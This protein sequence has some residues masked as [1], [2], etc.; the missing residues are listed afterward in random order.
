MLATKEICK[1]RRDAVGGKTKAYAY[2]V[3]ERNNKVSARVIVLD[4]K[5]SPCGTFTVKHELLWK[6]KATARRPLERKLARQEEQQRAAAEPE[7]AVEPT[8]PEDT[9]ILTHVQVCN[10]STLLDGLKC[11]QEVTING[12]STILTIAYDGVTNCTT[13]AIVN[14]ANEGQS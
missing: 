2:A 4:A 6:L 13:G 5:L 11:V 12:K 9:R 8:P 10:P 3:V 14:A 7:V 1:V